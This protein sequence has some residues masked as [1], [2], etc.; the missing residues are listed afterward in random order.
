MGLR[1]AEVFPFGAM[2]PLWRIRWTFI[3]KICNY[4]DVHFR[5]VTPPIQ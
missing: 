5:S 1:G 3:G 4:P 2:N